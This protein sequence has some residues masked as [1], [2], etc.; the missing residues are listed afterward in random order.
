MDGPYSE[1]VCNYYAICLSSDRPQDV[2]LEPFQ[3]QFLR[4]SARNLEAWSYTSIKTTLGMFESSQ[5]SRITTRRI[6]TSL[7]FVLRI[8]G[9]G[10]RLQWRPCVSL[11]IWLR[12]TAQPLIHSCR[13]EQSRPRLCNFQKTGTSWKLL[14]VKSSDDTDVENWVEMHA[15]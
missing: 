3:T 13:G 4:V 11:N 14:T 9:R 5:H 8:N 10:I 7:A 1:H 12:S 2:G 15:L 6:T